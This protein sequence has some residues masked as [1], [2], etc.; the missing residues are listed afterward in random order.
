MCVC[1]NIYIYFLVNST[2]KTEPLRGYMALLSMEKTGRWLKWWWWPLQ[3]MTDGWGASMPG[4][5]NLSPQQH[6]MFGFVVIGAFQL[7]SC[8]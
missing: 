6:P 3:S 5:Q 7:S 2:L 1:V 8:G 4:E